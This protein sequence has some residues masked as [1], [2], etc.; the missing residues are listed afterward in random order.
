MKRR[1]VSFLLASC[2]TIILLPVNALAAEETPE[3]EA[4]PACTCE[5]ACTADGMNAACP[6]CG[7]AGASPEGCRLYQAPEEEPAPDEADPPEEEPAPDEEGTPGE[8]PG[9]GE[10]D[11]Q[12]PEEE[13]PPPANDGLE[14]LSDTHANHGADGTAA[15][16][17]TEWEEWDGGSGSFGGGGDR[18]LY[19]TKDTTGSITV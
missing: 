7:A 4:P 12:A 17:I 9:D 15:D 1:V 13:T 2:M 16:P 14:P 11:G 6:V 3:P 8:M 18:Y 5:T 19:L 10:T